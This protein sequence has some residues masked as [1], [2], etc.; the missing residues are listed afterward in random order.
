METSGNSNHRMNKSF[1]TRHALRVFAEDLP[2]AFVNAG[3]E[4]AEEPYIDYSLCGFRAT[5]IRRY[6]LHQPLTHLHDGILTTIIHTVGIPFGQN[7]HKMVIMSAPRNLKNEPVAETLKLRLHFDSDGTPRVILNNGQENNQQSQ[8]E[9]SSTPTKS[10]SQH[11]E[12]EQQQPEEQNDASTSHPINELNQL[13]TY[14]KSPETTTTTTTTSFSH[15]HQRDYALSLMS[16]TVNPFIKTTTSDHQHAHQSGRSLAF[17]RQLNGYVAHIIELISPG[18][19]ELP[20]DMKLE[21]LKQLSVDSIIKMSQVNSEFRALI[22]KHGESLWRHLCSRDFN[23]RFINRLVHKNW[24]ELYRDTYLLRQAEICRKERALPGL[25]ERLA[26]PP[27]PYRLQ[28]EWLPEVL[29]LPFYPVNEFLALPRDDNPQ[30][31]LEFHPE[32]PALALRR[33]SSLDSLQ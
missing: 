27:V 29:E 30:L 17:I 26:L 7:G 10:V 2:R 4:I 32:L 18:L 33:A 5:Y 19:I 11:V 16:Q 13:A 8:S 25:P 15:E 6:I 9:T 12:E 14:F 3:F 31:A 28:I 22:F 24:M 1:Y 21:I 23:I 20:R